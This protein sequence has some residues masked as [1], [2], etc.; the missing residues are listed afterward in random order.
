MIQAE[1]SPIRDIKF[2]TGIVK[3]LLAGLLILNISI[4]LFAT[5][6]VYKSKQRF[7]TQAAINTHNITHILER[8]ISGLIDKIDLV[9]LISVDEIQQQMLAGRMDARKIND[10]LKLQSQRVPDIFNL[11][12]T[13]ENGDLLYGSDI[14][15]LPIVN[16]ADRDYFYKQRA[17]KSAGLVIGKPV[18]GKTTKKWLLTFSRRIN[19][20]DGTFGG[21]AY[22]TISLE[23]FKKLFAVVDT[24]PKG[25]VTL[26]DSELTMITSSGGF[27]VSG[28]LVGSKK[29]SQPFEASLKNHPEEGSYISG[30]T[31]I[32]QISRMHSY[33]KFEK[34]PFYI[35]SG[36]TEEVYLAGWHKQ[37]VETMAL[38][39]AFILLS[40]IFSF[41]LIR[42]LRR[43]HAYEE[44][45][46][47]QAHFD[48]LTGVDNRG[49]FMQQAELELSRTK[50]YGASLSM[51]M[52]DIDYFKQINDRHGHKI[53]DHVL[54]KLAE[55]CRETL[56]EVDIVG[57]VG[58]EEFAILLPETD[59]VEA[60][61]V[62]ER[63]RVAIADAKVPMENGLPIQFTV[64]I[65][66]SS[67]ATKDDNLDVLLNQA[68][69]ALYAAKETGRNKVC[70][71][72]E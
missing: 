36:V 43:Q 15:A 27:Q 48:Y 55:V 21:V 23:H 34:Y 19:K 72:T 25:T 4:A 16:Y 69:K 54:K 65:G 63:L 42:L 41:L 56:R 2:S 53:G 29:I 7:E 71:E 8:S 38:V 33:R 5:F 9:L 49:Y 30:A 17:S 68:D 61:E 6:E 13:N 1:Y 70:V 3:R 20:P 35:N 52:M 32:D 51:F 62:A 44:E 10:F 66:V 26:R 39:V 22:G 46:K 28:D 37:L 18:L 59:R 11:R 14:S 24:G 60:I 12:I 47:R 45:L 40:V 58:G 64:S 50:R 31:S 67:L 57:R